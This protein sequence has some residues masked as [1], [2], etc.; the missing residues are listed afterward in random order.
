[1][2]GFDS[3]EA[4]AGGD[5]A[6]PDAG[7]DGAHPDAGVTLLELL[8]PL[9]EGWRWLVLAPLAAGLVALGVTFVVSP[10]FT[11]RTTFLPPQ[12]QSQGQA[13]GALASLGAL[14]AL[15]GG[16]AGLRSPVDQY[17]SLMQS[18]TVSNRLIEEFGLREL[19]DVKLM[20][21]ARERL[22][23][24]VHIAVGR[25]D[26]L[27]TVEVEDHSPERAARIA[28]R[29]VDELR[30][31]T[32]E[33]ALTEAQQRRA[34]FEAQLKQTRDRLT[35]AQLALQA[36]GYSPGALKAEPRAAAE[37]YARLQA[38][39]TAAEVRLQTVRGAFAEGTPEVLQQQNQLAALRSQLARAEAPAERGADADYIGKYREFKYQ[40]T[41]F[42]LFARQFELARVDE[43]REGALV[44]VVDV[45]VPPERKSW[46]RRGLTAVAVTAATFLLAVLAL[47]GRQMWRRSLQLPG[48]AGHADRLRAA[49]GRRR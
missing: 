29:Y 8:V 1:M 25:K 9:A 31:V 43:S 47:T 15:A 20:V 41:L 37:R 49:L 10:L 5:A 39:V 3:T 48:H 18:T 6:H 27:V 34:F 19:Y 38:E 21:E 45:A 24:R 17:V 4:R 40:E 12:Q 42:E 33:L 26:G 46:P 28:N 7:G 22:A 13:L 16:A 11:A 14:G 36:S 44:Q 2:A 30:R 35:Q 32:S 23:R